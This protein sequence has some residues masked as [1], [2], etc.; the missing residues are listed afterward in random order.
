MLI[1]H[2]AFIAGLA[3]V[4]SVVD[5]SNA[6]TEPLKRFSHD[7]EVLVEHGENLSHSIM[8]RVA[9][10]VEERRS[11]KIAQDAGGPTRDVDSIELLQ[12]EARLGEGKVYR[13]R[14]HWISDEEEESEEFSLRLWNTARAELESSL[15]KT[16]QSALETV[17]STSRRER[18]RLRMQ[19]AVATTQLDQ[20]LK[21]L[22]SR[23]GAASG[24]LDQVREQL[25]GAVT[26]LRELKLDR[27]GLAARREAIDERVDELRAHA[28]KSAQ[29][30]PIL[31]ELRKIV[32]IREQQFAIDKAA[33]E[34]GQLSMGLAQQTEAALAQARIE[35]LR[36]QRSAVEGANGAILRELNNQLSQLI[37]EDAEL[38]AKEESLAQTVAELREMTS[39][40]VVAQ[41]AQL[42]QRSLQLRSQL[43]SLEKAL[44]DFE[45][46]VDDNS[47]GEVTIRPLEEALLGLDV[48]ADEGEGIP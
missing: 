10:I 36:A 13:L 8:Y 2:I 26:Q 46:Q 48:E 35:L 18:D 40:A 12:T 17:E 41:T 30:D 27:V 44:T 34:R 15:R 1:R 25:V 28:E 32:D 6:Q 45:L 21:E 11:T 31:D 4:C 38:R 29:D 5:R 24:T 20:V 39:A 3:V 43:D 9:N 14:V 23:A 37:V 16:Q 7:N 33:I 19:R 47:T 42:E 22:E